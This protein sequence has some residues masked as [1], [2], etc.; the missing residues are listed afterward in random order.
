MEKSSLAVAIASLMAS[1]LFCAASFFGAA[2]MGSS[3]VL[4]STLD[5][6]FSVLSAAV[7]IWR[8]SDDRNGLIGSKREKCGPIVFGVM[9]TVNGVITVVVSIVHISLD[10]RT[11]TDR[12]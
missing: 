2:T 5:A 8:F 9:F 7:V 3:A 1:L 10:G 6:L 11:Q 4:A 12:L